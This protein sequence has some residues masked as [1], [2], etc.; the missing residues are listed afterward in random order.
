MAYIIECDH[1][2]KWI[3]SFALRD[4][5][6]KLEPGYIMAVIGCNGAGKS[7]LV[8]TMLGSYKL[9][10]HGED[11]RRNTSEARKMAANKGDIYVEGYSVKSEGYGYKQ[12]IAYVLNE[13]PFDMN[14]SVK[15]TG[16]F[17]GSFYEGFDLKRYLAYCR[18]YGIS[19]T[20]L[21]GK[22]STG[23]Q[24]KLQLAFAQSYEAVLYI[25]DEPAGNLDVKFRKVLYDTMRELISEGDKSIIF[26][27][28]LVEEIENMADY[29]LWIEEGEQRFFG[30][31]ENLSDQY[32]LYNG[33]EPLDMLHENM[34]DVQIIGK[35]IR[36][37]HK[38]Y[39]LNGMGL[40]EQLPERIRKDC[41]RAGLKEIMYYVEEQR[42][43][44]EAFRKEW[45]R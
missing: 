11:Y 35:R 15:K 19:E 6:F 25:M 38:E 31:M 12:R 9:Y 16:E 37:T 30:S 18:E 45:D 23:E 1:I 24:I 26:V 33:E 3:G 21:V 2:T 5:H 22:L 7:T 42:M 44:S 34:C 28:H 10:N 43:G 13:C 20:K 40:V 14:L 4:I 41:R 27:T 39:L 29:I 36:E 17:Y 32:L 8:R